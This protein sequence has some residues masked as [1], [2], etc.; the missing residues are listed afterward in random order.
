MAQKGFAGG[1]GEGGKL[2]RLWDY[3]GHRAVRREDGRT[4]FERDGER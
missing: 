3:G 1:V 4:S 2:S